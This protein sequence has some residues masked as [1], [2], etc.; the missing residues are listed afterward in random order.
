MPDQYLLK[1]EQA[2]LPDRYGFCLIYRN[3]RFWFYDTTPFADFYI[4]KRDRENKHH[5]Y[6]YANKL[7]FNS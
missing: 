7:Y 3:V 4:W 2:L 6:Q 5:M 1:A